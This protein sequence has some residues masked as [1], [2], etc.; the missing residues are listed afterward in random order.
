MTLYAELN[1]PSLHSGA[2]APLPGAL[3]PAQPA[4]PDAVML[5]SEERFWPGDT[6]RLSATAPARGRIPPQRVIETR[7]EL[8]AVVAAGVPMITE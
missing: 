8:D 4:S 5:L 6:S 2:P 7:A 1:A 3:P